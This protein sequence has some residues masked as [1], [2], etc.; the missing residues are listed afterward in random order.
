[1]TFCTAWPYIVND[2]GIPG[3]WIRGVNVACVR[4]VRIVIIV[5]PEQS[6][7]WHVDDAPS[8]QMQVCETVVVPSEMFGA[9]FDAAV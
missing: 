8:A 6:V 7:G 2:V 4:T 5:E 1:M 3:K 9:S